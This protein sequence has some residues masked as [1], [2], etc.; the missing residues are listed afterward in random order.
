MKEFLRILELLRPNRF[1]TDAL[2]WCGLGRPMKDREHILRSFFMKSVYN[3][4]TTKVLI[5]NLKTNPSLRYLC[6]WESRS[7]VPS[8]ATFSRAF[9]IFTSERILEEVHT[10][11]IQ[12]NFPVSSSKNSTSRSSPG[13]FFADWIPVNQ[14]ISSRRMPFFTLGGWYCP[15]ISI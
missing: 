3:F 4:P 11:L 5:E 10:V 2:R 9:S 1:L 14:M 13:N 7:A 6:G 8:E 12:E 15:R